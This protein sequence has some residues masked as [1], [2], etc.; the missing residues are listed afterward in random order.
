MATM[1]G[2]KL[3]LFITDVTEVRGES[4]GV[5]SSLCGSPLAEESVSEQLEDNNE[6]AEFLA[7]T[8]GN[9]K[10]RK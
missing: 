1:P 6:E 5:T 8:A 4:S 7:S 10:K 2:L 3:L 9:L